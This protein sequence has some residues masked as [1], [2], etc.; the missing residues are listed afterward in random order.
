[1]VERW[2]VDCWSEY[3]DFNPVE[4]SAVQQRLVQ[5]CGA[6]IQ[7]AR[8]A[9]TSVSLWVDAGVAPTI[10]GQPVSQT[11]SAGQPVSLSVSATGSPAP[12]YQWK[13]NGSN[14]MGATAATYAIANAQ[15]VDTG[16]YTVVVSNLAGIVTSSSATLTVNVIPPGIT[17]QPANLAVSA[18]QSATF[19]V[20]ASGSAPLK[21]PVAEKW[22]EHH[23]CNIAE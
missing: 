22:G 11:V 19:S 20:V 13:K 15:A 8:R 6:A 2:S 21:L 23:W 14:I 4:C 16:T 5:C 17:T 18:G 10:T 7:E 12:S 9:S 1:M 3:L